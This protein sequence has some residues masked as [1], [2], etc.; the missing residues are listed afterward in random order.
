MTS[1]SSV[2]CG[3]CKEKNC[4]LRDSVGIKT[5]GRV[6]MHILCIFNNLDEKSSYILLNQKIINL[7]QYK[8]LY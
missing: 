7:N 3:K 6:E 4:F 1:L 2:L 5:A 8:I